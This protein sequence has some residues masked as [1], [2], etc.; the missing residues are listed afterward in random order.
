MRIAALS[1]HCHK[2]VLSR[3]WFECHRSDLVNSDKLTIIAFYCIQFIYSSWA[4][5]RPSADCVL[6]RWPWEWV[7]CWCQIR[8]RGQF[9]QNKNV[10]RNEH[11]FS[12][13]ILSLYTR[14]PSTQWLITLSMLLPWFPTTLSMLLPWLLLTMVFIMLPLTMLSMA[15]LLLPST[16]LFT[17]LLLSTMPPLLLV[18]METWRFRS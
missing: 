1:R 17:L 11:N 8:G 4:S 15:Q 13:H 18:E 3:T 6:P 14:P 7:Y 5:W 9:Q 10:W 16:T 12:R 2:C